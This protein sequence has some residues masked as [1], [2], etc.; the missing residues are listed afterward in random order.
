MN[1]KLE[2]KMSENSD[3][4]ADVVLEGN[5]SE[6]NE[7]WISYKNPELLLKY[8]SD[9]YRILPRRFNGLSAAQQR[10]LRREV[11]R[12]RFLAILPFVP[13]RKK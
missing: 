12:A 1:E 13:A 2:R 11:A 6:S 3:L 8:M 4:S 10:I 7:N 5:E 9:I